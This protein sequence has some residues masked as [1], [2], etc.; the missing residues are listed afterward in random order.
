MV[1]RHT[2]VAGVNG[3][4]VERV[5]RKL[6]CHGRHKAAGVFASRADASDFLCLLYNDLSNFSEKSDKI[7][8][9]NRPYRG[10]GGL[11]SQISSYF[12]VTRIMLRNFA[13]FKY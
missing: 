9:R 7:Y 8:Y 2:A 4:E 3:R 13:M 5:C 11:F 10:T 12:F 6:V 1:D